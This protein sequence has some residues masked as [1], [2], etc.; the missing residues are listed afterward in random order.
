MQ[1]P[2]APARS[3]VDRLV[4]RFRR[5]S[6]PEEGPVVR[7]RPAN[8]GRVTGF[9]VVCV[10][11]EG[12]HVEHGPM[13]VLAPSRNAAILAGW[14]HLESEHGSIGHLDFGQNPGRRAPRQA[15]RFGV[16]S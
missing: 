16:P 3:L 8:R 5:A 1:T 15:R 11:K 10:V 9:S 7:I 2:K 6:A 4:E 14:T 12:G 13:P